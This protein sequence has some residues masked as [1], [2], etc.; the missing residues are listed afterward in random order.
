MTSPIH[1][2]PIDT[3]SVGTAR[4]EAPS[5]PGEGASVARTNPLAVASLVSA[6]FVPLAAIVLGHVA[7]GQVARSGEQGRGL[8]VAALVLGYGSIALLAALVLG[9]VAF[10]LVISATPI[11]F[12]GAVAP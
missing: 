7:L 10:L 9:S 12:A 6:F 2:A 5:P 1:T 8:A 11:G 4:F 3:A